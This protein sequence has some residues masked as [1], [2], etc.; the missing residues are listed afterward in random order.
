MKVYEKPE[1]EKVVF[2]SETVADDPLT[3]TQGVTYGD[4]DEW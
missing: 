1:V 2:V 4:V 3:P